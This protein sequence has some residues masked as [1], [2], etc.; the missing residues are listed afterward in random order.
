MLEFRILGPVEVV[1][2][3]RSLPLGGAKQRAL[4]VDLT[5]HAN[6]VLS[7]DRLIDDLWGEEPPETA[8][9]LLHVY[10]SRLRKTLEDEGQSL[11]VTRAPGYLLRLEPPNELDAA[12]FEVE[13]RRGVELLD[14]R[15]A[16]ALETLDGA[17]AMWSGLAL[18]EF[19]EEPFARP[20]VARIEELRQS[21]LER[22][23]EALVA[24]GRHDE[25][26]V[27]LGALIARFPLRERLRELQMLAL[28]RSGRQ[29]DALQAFRSA[30]RTLADELGVDPS[31]A[32]VA[33][34]QSILRQDPEL[35]APEVSAAPRSAEAPAVSALGAPSR[36]R[37]WPLPVALVAVLAA[38]AVPVAIRTGRSPTPSPA[39]TPSPID[40]GSITWTEVDTTGDIFGGRGD[41]VILGGATTLEGLLAVGYSAA[42]RAGGGTRDYDAATWIRT[43]EGGWRRGL[44]PAFAMNGAQEATDA[45]AVPGRIVVVGSDSS[46]G[47]HDAAVW[48]LE[49]GATSWVQQARDAPGMHKRGNQYIRAVTWTGSTIVAVGFNH[50]G[51]GGGEDAAVWTSSDGLNWDVHT[52]TNLGVPGDQEMS[53]VT[54]F[55]DQVVAAGFTTS[56][57]GDGDAAVW[58]ADPNLNDWAAV[59]VGELAGSGDQQINAIIAAGPGLVAVGQETIGDDQNA[60][61]WV[62]SDG[63]EWE[64]VDDPTS[65]L[66][67]DGA[68]EI[69]A[70]VDAGGLVIAAGRDVSGVVGR[71]IDAAVWTSTDGRTWTRLSSDSPEA[72]TL[73]GFGG[74][75]IR[76]LLYVDGDI[77]ALGRERRGRDDDGDVWTG[78][79]SA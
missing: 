23:I 16:E 1:R 12:R 22:R 79:P 74:Q 21:T 31:S 30:R 49:D 24:L 10:V 76:A 37:A 26:L 34:E 53:S 57:T 77:L 29:A 43:D 18:E 46:Q 32:L 27:E 56:S 5:L 2:D 71:E 47:D 78:H 14:G 51:S 17:L 44:D 66:G 65:E 25:A 4:V 9:H 28:Y 64:R 54:T 36:R 42:P 13:A 39:E 19:A 58:T 8:S 7:A 52:P 67:G 3:G 11:L 6:E 68:Q 15:P 35:D 55:G 69:S 33:L 62:S 41:Q 60:V 61:V 73:A 45:V 59:P 38:V 75:A 48:T 40:A 63:H 70:V 20:S 72:S 50:R